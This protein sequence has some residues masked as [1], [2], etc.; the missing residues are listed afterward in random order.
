MLSEQWIDSFNIIQ[1]LD[2]RKKPK[3]IWDTVAVKSLGHS[4]KVNSVIITNVKPFSMS[5][6]YQPWNKK[7]K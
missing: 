5:S 4:P 7:L 6:N 3:L 1:I 2:S